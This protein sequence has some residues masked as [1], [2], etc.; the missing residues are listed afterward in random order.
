MDRNVLRDV[1]RVDR[2]HPDDAGLMADEV[3]HAHAA[4][5]SASACPP[6]SLPHTTGPRD[7]VAELRILGEGELKRSVLPVGEVLA[8]QL[9]EEGASTK[10]NT[11]ST[12]R[13]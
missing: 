7:D 2:Q 6:S 8:D 9:R 4:A 10:A 5:L 12:L 3:D 13:H 11:R 1:L